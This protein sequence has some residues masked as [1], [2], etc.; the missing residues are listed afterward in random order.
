MM[1]M[2][3]IDKAMIFVVYTLGIV[4]I[5]AYACGEYSV[6]QICGF[7]MIGIA[8]AGLIAKRIE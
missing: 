1:E 8:L 2:K 3:P 4:G 7:M 5:T 6:G